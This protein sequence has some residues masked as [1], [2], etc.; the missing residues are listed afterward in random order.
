MIAWRRV[1]LAFGLSCLGA[2]PLLAQVDPAARWR[3][4]A[5]RHFRVHFT[6]ATEPIARRAAREAERAY[7]TLARE[8]TPPRG[9]VE[10]VISDGA[11]F[12]NGYATTYPTNRIVIFAR[13][14]LNNESLRFVDDWIS[15]VVTHEL[16]HI[17]HLDRTRG[18]WRLG[19]ALLGRHPSLFPNQYSP[20]W[21]TEGLAVHYESRI[22][23]AGR[24]AGSE[25]RMI[26]RAGLLDGG[27]F[28]RLDELS[29]GTTRFPYGAAAY[30]YGSLLVDDLARRGG[31]GS[32]RRF[33]DGTAGQL[34]PFRIEPTARRAFGITLQDAFAHWRDSLR[35]T[36]AAPSPPMAGWRIIRPAREYAVAPRWVNDSAL[37]I[38]ANDGRDVSHAHL[39][40]PGRDVQLSRRNNLDATAP[41]PGGAV[42]AQLDFTT[43]Y[44]IRS[45]L[46]RE[47]D[48]GARRLTRG[49]R[50]SQPDV[51]GE[52]RIVA[53]QTLPG[54]SRLVVM[55]ASA[56]G[57]DVLA[58]GSLDTTWSEPRWSPDGARVV[59]SRWRRGGWSAIVLLDVA[60]RL[61]RVLYES[62]AVN[63]APSFT[64]D[65]SRVVYSSDIS[66][67]PQLYV[68]DAREGATPARLSDSRTGMFE[69]VVS[70]DGQRVAALQYRAGG[71]A[72]GEGSLEPLAHPD[73]ATRVPQVSRTG[74]PDSVTTI[75]TPYRAFRQ[76]LPRYWNP[77]LVSEG[78]G[79]ALVGGYTSAE[80][81]IGRHQWFAQAL[82]DTREHRVD[83]GASYRWAGL[84]RP[85]L[86]LTANQSNEY[87][88]V[89]VRRAGV[90]DDTARRALW[91][92]TRSVSL[93][94]TLARP[95]V[96]RNM[97]LSG[98]AAYEWREYASNDPRLLDVARLVAPAPVRP[99]YPSVFMSALFAN[100]RRPTRAISVEDGISVA[101]TVRQRWLR[102]GASAI[103][104]TAIGVARAYKSLD[105]P[106]Y[107]HHVLAFRGSVG[108][109][110]RN[111]TS[112]LSVGGTSGAAV[113][114]I[115]T[116]TIGGEPRTF[117]VRGYLPG[118]QYGL[119]AASGT[120][121]YRAPMMS[122][123]RGYRLLPIFFDRT[124]LT[125]FA[126][127]GSA[128]C[129]ASVASNALCR[130]VPMRPR[131][132]GSVGAELNLNAA[133]L[134]YDS[135]YRMRLGVAAPLA[136]RRATGV[137]VAR[138]YF[139]FGTSF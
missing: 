6:A 117:P 49:A 16:V 69:P 118:T 128:W 122:V 20:R 84:G 76:L 78:D 56:R 77:M 23:G 57:T 51:N 60:T 11:D 52:G 96:R 39:V 109:T 42:F 94:A 31:P 29:L 1:L 121:E 85:L 95:R 79:R 108:A 45:D 126:D 88:G 127:G 28:N 101:G 83:G 132:L 22:T 97:A 47:T 139:T 26:A 24:I 100:P 13:P 123:L 50:L 68:V 130:T 98:G 110:D 48:G 135:Q 134:D 86:D 65:G 119:A 63:A 124:S 61:S 59:A 66:G 27:G 71:Y 9:L 114:I 67:A 137:P 106:G 36:L 14:P 2:G 74:P 91:R 113:E 133:V 82:F 87:F 43:P 55:D 81:V 90:P 129:P 89:I 10:L 70:P 17:F 30:A 18:L 4:I 40:S 44:E 103:T 131:W 5:T 125:L 15:L 41:A 111:G 32:I 104:R 72:L 21:V 46:Y 53:V 93:A 112:E 99:T 12:S 136:E 107:A 115:P 92:R 73:T 38:V 80:D 33:V 54:T 64:P 116:V 25:H 120:V 8:L 7:D 19:Q 3:T 62:R 37:L 35:A 102:D 34:I 58:N 105:L 138:A 75:A